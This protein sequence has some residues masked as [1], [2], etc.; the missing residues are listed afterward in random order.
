MSP[1]S[2]VDKSRIFILILMNIIIIGCAER[3][4]NELMQ[5]EVL[6]KT[7]FDKNVI[8]SVNSFTLIEKAIMAN[9]SSLIPE[10]RSDY[11]Y[12]YNK[13]EKI[14]QPKIDLKSKEGNEY[15]KFLTQK[16]MLSAIKIS[17]DS[18]ITFVIR[19]THISENRIDIREQLTNKSWQV[20]R[21]KQNSFAKDTMIS[22]WNYKI[23]ADKRLGW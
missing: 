11:T 5:Q 13:R 22:G 2:I 1:T 10:G 12:I 3:S 6:S 18:S 4:S 21:M 14:F 8:N 7:P 23:W 16:N 17:R 20:K 9:I 15:V 19:N